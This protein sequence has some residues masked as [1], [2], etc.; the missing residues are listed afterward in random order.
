MQVAADAQKKADEADAFRAKVKESCA[1]CFSWEEV[2]M[3]AIKVYSLWNV[4][5]EGGARDAAI[6]HTA[7]SLGVGAR[8]V[9]A[10][11]QDPRPRRRS[12]PRPRLTPH[13]RPRPSCLAPRPSTLDPRASRLDLVLVVLDLDPRASRLDLV[14]VVLDLDPRA[15]YLDPRPLTLDPRASRLDLVLVVLASSLPSRLDLDPRP[16][17]M[18]ACL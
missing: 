4:A 16:R 7:T 6:Q 18:L 17:L 13:P 12:P 8:S 10:W 11:L 9:Y 15:S 14:L 3:E 1:D 5:F 2:R